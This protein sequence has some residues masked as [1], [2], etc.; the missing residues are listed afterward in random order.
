MIR[1]RAK[2]LLS[3]SSL[4]PVVPSTILACGMGCSLHPEC[5]VLC[6]RLRGVPQTPRARPLG[7]CA[8]AGLSAYL[9]AAVAAPSLVTRL[10]RLRRLRGVCRPLAA[11]PPAGRAPSPRPAGDLRR[12]RCARTRARCPPCGGGGDFAPH[13]PDAPLGALRST[14][15][16]RL[17]AAIRRSSSTLPSRGSPQRRPRWPP[18][19]YAPR[20][21]APLAGTVPS[22]A[23]LPFS[24]LSK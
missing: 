14:S 22:P 13:G 17:A 16:R 2:R 3:W 5:Q 8:A 21:A 10:R 12:T 19:A 4:P 6:V 18:G 24:C 7:G 15:S 1:C 11:P 9:R 23:P 20:F